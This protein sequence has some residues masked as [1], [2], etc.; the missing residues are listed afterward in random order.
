MGLFFALFY[1]TYIPNTLSHY[2]N[3]IQLNTAMAFA[4]VWMPISYMASVSIG[5]EFINIYI[6]VKKR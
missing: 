4:F 5:E 6:M 1:I 3:L 2:I